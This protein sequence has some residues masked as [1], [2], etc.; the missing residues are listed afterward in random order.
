M[1]DTD[2]KWF[3]CHPSRKLI[4][5]INQSSYL[6]YRFL[7]YK[8]FDRAKETKIY[9]IKLKRLSSQ[10]FTCFIFL[11]LFSKKYQDLIEED[12]CPEKVVIDD[13]ELDGV[14]INDTENLDDLPRFVFIDEECVNLKVVNI[15]ENLLEVLTKRK[16]SDVLQAC[17]CSLCDKPCR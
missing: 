2:I 14:N 15:M 8:F 7:I 5:S 12:H 9:E 6:I 16:K 4:V 17:R 13:E 1:I 11:V 3:L 10:I